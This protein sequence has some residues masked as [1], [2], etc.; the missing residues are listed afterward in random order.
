M[1][2]IL[3]G[4]KGCGKTHFGKLLATRTGRR[5]IDTDEMLEETF[6]ESCRALAIRIGREAFIQCE[7][8]IVAALQG[9]R[10]AIIALG[11]GTLMHPENARVICTLGTVLYM[12]EEKESVKKRLLQPPLP[13]FIDPRD[14]EG[15]FERMYRERVPVYEN[16][17]VRTIALH[18]LS[19]E[20]ILSAL[21]Q[22]VK[23]G[24]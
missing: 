15:S 9:T 5:F 16:C 12:Q 4:F 21:E 3:S 2:L 8:K 22:E 10:H 19:E 11:G 13:T 17:A 18:A 1:N 6:H 20:E 14:P 7:R 23:H 24:K